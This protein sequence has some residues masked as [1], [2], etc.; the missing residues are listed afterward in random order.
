VGDLDRDGELELTVIAAAAAARLPT[1]LGY[2]EHECGAVAFLLGLAA[3]DVQARLT[4]EY[5]FSRILDD[6][7]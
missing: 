2:G 1:A 4:R 6:L 5:R 3:L 7:S